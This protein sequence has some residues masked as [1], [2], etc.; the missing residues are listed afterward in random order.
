MQTVNRR[1]SGDVLAAI[2]AYKQTHDGNSPSYRAIM[3]MTG[4]YSTS[5]IAYH[6]GRLEDAGLIRRPS[7][8]GGSRMIEVVGGQWN[9]PGGAFS[10]EPCITMPEQGQA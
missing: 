3:D 5:T 1:R 2:I 6:L 8:A 9:P 7:R 4:L 10:D